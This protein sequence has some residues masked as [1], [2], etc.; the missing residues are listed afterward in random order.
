[1]CRGMR[2]EFLYSA[3]RVWALSGRERE[4]EF[5][6]LL[7]I[8]TGGR[9]ILNRE[10]KLDRDSR[11]SLGAAWISSVCWYPRSAAIM[12]RTSLHIYI[13][14]A[15]TFARVRAVSAC[16][17]DTEESCKINRAPGLLSTGGKKSIND[18]ARR[19]YLFGFSL[20]SFVTRK[21]TFKCT[22]TTTDS[23]C[24]S[25]LS[26]IRNCVYWLLTGPRGC[27]AIYVI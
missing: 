9:A 20:V 5:T 22:L 3:C 16:F 15:C 7:D 10:S 2:N 24:E 27:P 23:S 1:M 18:A 19:L 11:V 4:R 13:C 12:M 26:L 6:I 14:V 25:N 21:S 8:F 17:V